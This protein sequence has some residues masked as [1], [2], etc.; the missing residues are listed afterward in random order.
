MTVPDIFEP[1]SM[2]QT[3]FERYFSLRTDRAEDQ[4]E[5]DMIMIQQVLDSL[6]EFEKEVKIPTEY[7]LKALQ[8]LGGNH[9]E[10]NTAS[11]SSTEEN[12][13]M[14]QEEIP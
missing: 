12:N 10:D 1:S 2:L 11:A 8:E 14:H 5:Q 6:S 13:R 4:L 3:H 9:G 7:W